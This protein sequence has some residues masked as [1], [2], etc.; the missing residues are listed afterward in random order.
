M[1]LPPVVDRVPLHR[2]VIDCRGYRRADGRFDVEAH[3]VDT[4]H[5]T[6]AN[7]WRGPLAPATPIHDMYLRLTIDPDLTIHDAAASTDGSPYAVCGDITPA[8]AALKGLKIG[9]GF[10]RA[11]RQRLGGV[12]GC[13]HL[14]ELLGPL[15]TTALQTI[16]P[17]RRRHIPDEPD[18]QPPRHLDTC[19]ALRRD[20]PV[21]REHHPA[22]YTGKP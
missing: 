21:V 18:R 15:A 9:P 11:V 22:W 20:G 10:T 3:L 7:R 12:H 1:P 2:R 8:F 19:H 14:V 17:L 13:T 16:L 5:Y 4:K 6:V